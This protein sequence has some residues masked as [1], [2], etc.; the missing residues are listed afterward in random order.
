MICLRIGDR[1]TPGQSAIVQAHAAHRQPGTI[2]Y[3][4][5]ER[6]VEQGRPLVYVNAILNEAEGC[7]LCQTQGA[8][9]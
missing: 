3:P 2:T 9:R 5:F 8:R 7:P 6:W 1:L 4:S